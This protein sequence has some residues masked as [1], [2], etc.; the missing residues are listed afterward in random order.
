[1]SNMC[2]CE[3]ITELEGNEALDYIDS[4]LVKIKVDGKNW[5]ITYKCPFTAIKWLKDYPHS[6]YHGGGSPRL[7]KLPLVDQ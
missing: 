2:K 7:R 6:E 4:H 3:E 1:M 5:E